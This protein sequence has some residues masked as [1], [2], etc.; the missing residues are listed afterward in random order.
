VNLVRGQYMQW[1]APTI[2]YNAKAGIFWRF[3]HSHRGWLAKT[4]GG[5]LSL[6]FWLKHLCIV[7]SCGM[8]H[9]IMWCGC[10]CDH[11]RRNWWKLYYLLCTSL[12]TYYLLRYPYCLSSF[13]RNWISLLIGVVVRSAR[14]IWT[15]II[16][17]TTFRKHN[18]T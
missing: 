12:A 4:A 11:L 17:V 9:K 8:H 2:N 10:R 7:S 5:K 13:K 15:G 14:A 6:G 18:L 3:A 1:K 16:F